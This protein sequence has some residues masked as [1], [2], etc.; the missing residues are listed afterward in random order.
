M[1]FA[2]IVAKTATRD[3]LLSRFLETIV[4]DFGSI[5]ASV[6]EA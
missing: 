5:V 4:A 6:D 1:E 2:L 3:D